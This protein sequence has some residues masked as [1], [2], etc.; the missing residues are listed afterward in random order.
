VLTDALYPGWE[1]TLDGAPAQ[2]Y[3]ADGLFRGV[4]VPAGAHEVV[5]AFRPGSF[6]L[7]VGVSLVGLAALVAGAAL[8]WR[9]RRSNTPRHSG[10]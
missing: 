5:F 2:L 7:G 3:A 9:G 10:E 1:A 4:L 8:A 6:R